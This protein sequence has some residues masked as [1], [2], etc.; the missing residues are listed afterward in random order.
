MRVPRG[1]AAG[2]AHP[3]HR[4]GTW[5]LGRAS[6]ALCASR[7]WEK[8]RAGGGWF[9]SGDSWRLGLGKLMHILNYGGKKKKGGRLSPAHAAYRSPAGCGARPGTGWALRIV[10][11]RNQGH[12]LNSVVNNPKS[13]LLSMIAPS[14]FI[15]NA[16]LRLAYQLM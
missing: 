3:E 5:G 16:G 4:L 6:P 13:G 9:G 12:L 8:N 1:V 7:C 15:L 10:S 2:A 11:R 14:W